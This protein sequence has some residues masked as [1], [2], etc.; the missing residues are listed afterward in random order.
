MSIFF[1]LFLSLF[2]FVKASSYDSIQLTTSVWLSGAAYCDKDNYKTMK[3]G[4]PATNFVYKDTIYDIKTDLQGYVG[5]LSATKSIYVVLRG[6]SSVMNW[7]DDFEVRLVPYATY[8]DCN[9]KVHNGFY[10]SALGVSNKT[11]DIVKVLKKLYPTYSVIVT[12]HSYGASVGQLLAMELERANIQTKLYNYGQP[13]VGDNKYA[14]FVN[15]LISEY[16]RTT[17]NKDIVPHVPPIE[18]FGYL[19]SC[20][21]IFEDES[22]N[23]TVCSES[24]CEDP[25]CA[26]KYKLYQTNGDDHGVYLKH[27]MSCKKS[28]S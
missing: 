10:R 8:P 25:K 1:L 22:G 18:V 15:T 11:I 27:I 21:E 17:H 3:L 16:Y 26:D 28:T 2:N 13:R 23:L 6:S 9:C 24:D 19:H 7:L 14:G 12:G 5:L 4:G 20:R